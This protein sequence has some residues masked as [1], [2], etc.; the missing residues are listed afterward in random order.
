MWC[1]HTYKEQSQNDMSLSRVPIICFL[2]FVP[3]LK[4]EVWIIYHGDG[5]MGEGGMDMNEKAQSMFIT[6]R[7]FVK[8]YLGA[9]QKT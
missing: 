5:G 8:C 9:E 4:F 6:F 7:G 1:L 2:G 3:T